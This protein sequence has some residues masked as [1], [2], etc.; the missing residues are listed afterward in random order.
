MVLPA[1]NRLGAGLVFVRGVLFVRYQQ[2]LVA[3]IGIG[4]SFLIR[5]DLGHLGRNVVVGTSGEAPD[6]HLGKQVIACQKAVP[7]VAR[8]GL[9]APFA[10]IRRIHEH[11]QVGHIAYQQHRFDCH[12]GIAIG[13]LGLDL[14]GGAADRAQAQEFCPDVLALLELHER[15]R[16]VEQ[17]V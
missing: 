5:D 4:I 8:D 14:V 15:D 6:R 3:P 10:G 7:V 17:R 9:G 2:D 1:A 16:G 12:L 11:G 13:D